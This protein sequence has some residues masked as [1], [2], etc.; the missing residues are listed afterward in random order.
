M[1][2]TIKCV[3]IFIRVKKRRLGDK[4]LSQNVSADEYIN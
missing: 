1:V 3:I 4:M 2:L